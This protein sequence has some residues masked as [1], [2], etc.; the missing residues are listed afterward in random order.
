M[1]FK[2]PISYDNST[3]DGYKWSRE[4]FALLGFA[5]EGLCSDDSYEQGCLKY[6]PSLLDDDQTCG[7]RIRSMYKSAKPIKVGERWMWEVFD[8]REARR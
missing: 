5:S 4:E 2:V 8:S 7:H 6:L 1:I 3:V